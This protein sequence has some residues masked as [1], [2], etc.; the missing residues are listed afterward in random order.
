VL[1]FN[2]EGR[3][4]VTL[5]W[6]IIRSGGRWYATGTTLPN[7]MDNEVLLRELVALGLS[8]DSEVFIIA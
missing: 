3:D 1:I 8:A 7:G 4:D 6:A 5:H 2:T